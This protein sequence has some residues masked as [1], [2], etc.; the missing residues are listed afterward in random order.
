MIL[1]YISEEITMSS[2]QDQLKRCLDRHGPE[3]RMA[4]QIRNQIAAE[5]TGKSAQDL[6]ITGSVERLKKSVVLDN[7]KLEGMPETN[8]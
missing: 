1:K 2:L 8:A 6:Y 4:Q 3:S 5:K 7:A